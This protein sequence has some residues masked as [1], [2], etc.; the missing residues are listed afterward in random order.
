[1]NNAF[2]FRS[3]HL[4]PIVT[5]PVPGYTAEE[6]GETNTDSYKVFVKDSEGPI[7]PFHDIPLASGDNTFHMVVEVPR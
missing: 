6:R 1:M 3:Y 4:S 2:I 5:M 7:S